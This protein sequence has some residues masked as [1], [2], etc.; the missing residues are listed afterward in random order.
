[1]PQARLVAGVCDPGRSGGRPHRGQLQLIA[2]RQVKPNNSN[3][4][5][6]R[7]DVRRRTFISTI[8]PKSALSRR[9][10]PKNPQCGN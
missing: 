10:H 8:G 3:N 9:P 6:P 4:N 1:M 7:P 5:S 2:L